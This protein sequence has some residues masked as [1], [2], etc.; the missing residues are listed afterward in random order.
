MSHPPSILSLVY[1]DLGAAVRSCLT[2]TSPYFAHA[3]LTQELEP[4]L[5]RLE[6]LEQQ[7]PALYREVAD[8]FGVE[9][10]GVPAA[11]QDRAAELLDRA[12]QDLDGGTVAVSSAALTPDL[13]ARRAGDRR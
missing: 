5:H 6:R 13:V 1:R 7:R 3:R 2:W 11:I 8:S 4:L 12:L 10:A 9:P